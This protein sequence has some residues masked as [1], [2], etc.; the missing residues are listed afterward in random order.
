MDQ[1]ITV[2][3]PDGRL[4][5]ARLPDVQALSGSALASKTA[6]GDQVTIDCQPIAE[7]W[8]QT[9]NLPRTLEMKTIRVHRSAK[10]E[11]M[12]RAIQCPDWRR[13]GNLLHPPDDQVPPVKPL[14]APA[15][16]PAGNASGDPQAVLEK[17][18]TVNLDRVS[19]LPNF[20]ADEEVNCYALAA[21]WKLT[22]TVHSE[23]SFYGMNQLRQ[24]VGPEGKLVP[25]QGTP[26][27]CLGWSGGFGT[28]IRPVFDPL[29]GTTLTYSKTT[30][31][32]GKQ[33]L[34][35]NF[36]TPLEGECYPLSFSGF[37][38]AYAAH[39]G[40]VVIDMASGELISLVV[41]ARG[42]PKAYGVAKI[43]ETSTWGVVKVEGGPHL[44]PV[45]YVKTLENGNGD[46]N[47]VS[48]VYSKHRHFEANA[49][50]APK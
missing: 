44:L 38:R 18:R 7:V 19:H 5:D 41:R 12:A 50:I 35:Y 49:S 32:S 26:E 37:E 9:V 33:S 20:V 39:E 6:F 46:T 8:D 14:P 15:A 3:L 1:S 34:I 24:Q 47:K 25:S 30:G 10:P 48:A 2:L 42:F 29:C 28:Y 22:A 11:E 36:S 40:S 43:E 21:A 17:A 45:S 31:K 23:V 27:G 4:I 16:P 13:P